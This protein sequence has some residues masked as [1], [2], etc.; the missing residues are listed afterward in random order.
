MGRSANKSFYH[1][2]VTDRT[3]EA[4]RRYFHTLKQVSQ[5]YGIS[6]NT[7]NRRLNNTDHAALKHPNLLFKRVHVPVFKLVVND[8]AL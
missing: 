1:Y 5:A 6:N 2:E 3:T 8:D 4:A 7:I